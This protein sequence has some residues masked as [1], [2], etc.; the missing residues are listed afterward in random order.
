MARKLLRY[1]SSQHITA[2]GERKSFG[3]LRTPRVFLV[4][5]I[6]L[7]Y[8]IPLYTNCNLTY[9][10]QTATHCM[11]KKPW[12]ILFSILTIYDGTKLL[13][14]K[15]LFL[16]KVQTC[17]ELPFKCF[18]NIFQTCHLYTSRTKT[19]NKYSST[20]DSGV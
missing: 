12:P 3:P 20:M 19:Y 5:I 13:K 1:W 4:E 11:Y 17:F 16:L 8:Q 9:F 10:A 6:F 15:D 18:K 14:R 2:A 7:F